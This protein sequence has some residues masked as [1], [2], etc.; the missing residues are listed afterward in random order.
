MTVT[1]AAVEEFFNVSRETGIP[2]WRGCCQ[3]ISVRNTSAIPILV[4][5]A[6]LKITK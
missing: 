5:A 2:I 4:Q 1:P 3:T 6:N